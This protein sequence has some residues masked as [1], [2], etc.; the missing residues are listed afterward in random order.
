MKVED[1]LPKNTYLEYLPVDHQKNL[2][3]L[4]NN[5]TQL[6]EWLGFAIDLSNAYRTMAMHIDIYKRERPKDPI[7]M[8]SKHLEGNA[9][10]A[11]D[12]KGLIRAWLKTNDKMLKGRFWM[13]MLGYTPGYVHFQQVPPGSGNFYF[14]PW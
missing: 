13:E 11:R 12:P 10:D 7:P 4:A 6:E 14:K 5:G 3:R 1:L 8:H 2:I 9:F